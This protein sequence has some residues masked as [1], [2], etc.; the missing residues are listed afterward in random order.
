M[1]ISGP[2]MT[3][4]NKSMPLLYIAG[5]KNM[6]NLSAVSWK[7]SIS[8]SQVECLTPL[9]SLFYDK[10]EFTLSSCREKTSVSCIDVTP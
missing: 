8:L 9:V 2:H 4:I 10:K 6:Q 1:N 7:P 5:V 3:L